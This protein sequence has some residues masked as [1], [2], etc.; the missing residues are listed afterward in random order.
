MRFLRDVLNGSKELIRSADVK[1]FNVPRFPEFAVKSL[2]K[3]VEKD[4][5]I[6]KH[7]N[8]YPDES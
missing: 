6:M 4:E 5:L 7:L 2:I 1:H 8:H 3:E